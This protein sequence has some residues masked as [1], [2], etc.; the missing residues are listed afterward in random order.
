MYNPET[1]ATLDTQDT[2]QGK[3]KTENTAQKTK[4]M[5]NTDPTKYRGLTHVLAKDKQFLL[6]LKLDMFV[7]Y[8]FYYSDTWTID[9][10][11]LYTRTVVTG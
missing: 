7:G 2:G 5:S 8:D 3:T 4:K 6:L 1:L 9:T 11:V 10:L